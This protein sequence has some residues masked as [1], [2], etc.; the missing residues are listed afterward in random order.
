MTMN[1][2]ITQYVSCGPMASLCPIPIS[3][4]PAIEH[5]FSFNI[6]WSILTMERKT[7]QWSLSLPSSLQ[8]LSTS[9][10]MRQKRGPRKSVFT[11]CPGFKRVDILGRVVITFLQYISNHHCCD[12]VRSSKTQWWMVYGNNT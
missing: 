1:S 10:L 12:N 2:E 6:T 9:I 7:R 11:F 3:N 8:Q 5:A 4:I